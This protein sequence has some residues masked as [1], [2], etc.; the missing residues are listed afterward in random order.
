[1]LAINLRP[2]NKLIPFPASHSAYLEDSR[3]RKLIAT[4]A[5]APNLDDVGNEP[6]TDDH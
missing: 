6:W 2:T 1:M 4:L 5:L 3:V